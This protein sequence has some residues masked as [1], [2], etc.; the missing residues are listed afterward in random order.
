M[1]TFLKNFAPLKWSLRHL[2]FL[3]LMLLLTQFSFATKN[4]LQYSYAGE[5]LIDGYNIFDYYIG[6]NSLT[7]RYVNNVAE[8]FRPVESLRFGTITGARF[9]GQYIGKYQMGNLLS[10]TTYIGQFDTALSPMLYNKIRF[11]NSLGI[12]STLILKKELVKIQLV[13]TQLNPET[14]GDNNWILGTRL[15]VQPFNIFPNLKKYI[16]LEL[17]GAILSHH[18]GQNQEDQW[19]INSTTPVSGVDKVF[20]FSDDSPLDIGGGRLYSVSIY[21]DD[22][23]VSNVN[24]SDLTSLS[25]ISTVKTSS[26]TETSKKSFLEVDFTAAFPVNQEL[27]KKSVTYVFDIDNDYKIEGRLSKTAAYQTVSSSAGKIEDGSNRKKVRLVYQKTTIN[28]IVGGGLQGQILGIKL[29]GE[30]YARLLDSRSQY[31]PTNAMAMYFQAYRDIY[32]SRISASFYNVDYFFK[33]S[34]MMPDN[35]NQNS[36]LDDSENENQPSPGFFAYNW[37]VL[38]KY[39]VSYEEDIRYDPTSDKNNNYVKDELEDD[40]LSDYLFQ[41]GYRGFELSTR[42]MV[43]TPLQKISLTKLSYIDVMYILKESSRNNPDSFKE[44]KFLATVNLGNEIKTDKLDLLV[45][46]STTASD[47]RDSIADDNYVI[48]DHSTD[49]GIF[50][51]VNVTI[52]YYSDRRDFQNSFLLHS[53]ISLDAKTS[54]GL[55]FSFSFD[56][57]HH[58]QRNIA[59]VKNHGHLTGKLSYLLKIPGDHEMYFMYKIYKRDTLTR[60]GINAYSDHTLNHLSD[61]D[62]FSDLFTRFTFNLSKMSQFNIYN[63]FIYYLDELHTEKSYVKLYPEV[64]LTFKVLH[65]R[66]PLVLIIGANYYYRQAVTD[67]LGYSTAQN[68]SEGHFFGRLYFQM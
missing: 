62:L 10:S 23:L 56:Y 49:N 67:P 19:V 33:D 66:V 7:E 38:P 24:A 32:S 21:I 22:T 29:R 52:P 34:S 61:K 63:L 37:Y 15:S 55:K 1:K 46:F 5:E 4:L 51:G 60:P 26:Y 2:L 13:T 64:N 58:N 30:I 42:I 9:G 17:H 68:K 41:P 28:H 39:F 50:D 20:R 3:V 36:F 12:F 59:E 11:D 16:S 35:D 47:I 14:D 40:Q 6:Y 53:A 65:Q 45:G 43:P 57:Y 54:V 44:S 27:I 31:T 48:E 18:Y 25:E 8:G